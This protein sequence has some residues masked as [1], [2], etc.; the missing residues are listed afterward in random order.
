LKPTSATLYVSWRRVYEGIEAPQAIGRP[1][2][3]G[4]WRL[5]CA[6]RCGQAI[7]L[8]LAVVYNH[9]GYV[10]SHEL[11][12][13]R[14]ACPHCGARV[15]ERSRLF[16]GVQAEPADEPTLDRWHDDGGD[17][18]PAYAAPAKAIGQRSQAMF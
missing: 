1:C 6:C 9:L 14:T 8:G 13:G 7:R 3:S 11:S 4:S 10:V 17:V 16:Q 5:D 12:P 2:V 18:P 15:S